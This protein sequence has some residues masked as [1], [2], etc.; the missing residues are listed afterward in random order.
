MVSV[1]VVELGVP[2]MGIMSFY[3]SHGKVRAE[4]YPNYTALGDGTTDRV[5]GGCVREEM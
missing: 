2:W 1:Q 3:S 5:A 4:S